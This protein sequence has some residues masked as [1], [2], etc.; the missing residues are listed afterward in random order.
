MA[1]DQSNPQKHKWWQRDSSVPVEPGYP[2]PEAAQSETAVSTSGDLCLLTPPK[3]DEQCPN[4]QQG[5]LAYDG[6]FLLTCNTCHKVAEG[7]CFT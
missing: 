6:L 7:G 2:W 4:C 1:Q 3:P 5:T